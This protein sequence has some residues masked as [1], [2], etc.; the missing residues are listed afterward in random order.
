MLRHWLERVDDRFMGTPLDVHPH[1]A[2]L[3]AMRLAAGEVA[4][5][6]AQVRRLSE[7]ELFERPNKETWVELPSGPIVMVEEKR[8]AE[9]VSRWVQL[10]DNAA[11]RMAKYGEMAIRVGVEERRIKLAEQE[12][13]LVSR[14]FEAVLGDL[15]L[16]PQQFQKVGPAMRKHLA[17]V[18]GVA[19]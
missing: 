11:D 3:H 9:V 15:N 1:D 6:D 10:R 2:I 5:C 13:N 18:E 14:F 12:A 7:D 8:D 17:L 4:Y 16:S 19:V